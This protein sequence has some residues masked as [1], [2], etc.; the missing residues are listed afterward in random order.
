MS[1]HN[2]TFT[3]FYHSAVIFNGKASMGDNA[4]ATEWATGNRFCNN[5]VT[6]CSG[7]HITD[8]YASGSLGVGSQDGLQIYNNTITQTSRPEG[9][10][11]YLIK[12]FSNGYN[13]NLK[14]YNNTLVKAAPAD[15]SSDWNFAIELWNSQG[16]LEIYDNTVFGSIDIAGA[17]G[18]A[19][20]LIMPGVS[21]TIL[22][23]TPLFRAITPPQATEVSILKASIPVGGMPTAI[24]LD[25]SEPRCSSIRMVT[26]GFRISSSTIIFSAE[27]A[28]IAAEVGTICLPGPL[29]KFKINCP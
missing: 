7:W 24:S 12:Y 3:N 6:N 8:G 21:T 20:T 14:I 29:P 17:T 1:I 10:N 28:S 15:R 5:T 2:A 22:L 11:G 16:G 4:E 23:A 9:E 27:S 25:L 13:R 19:R 26:I 18:V